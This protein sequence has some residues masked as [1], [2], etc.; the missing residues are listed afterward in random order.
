MLVNRISVVDKWALANE[1]DGVR[2]TVQA[3]E[4]AGFDPVDCL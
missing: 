4:E 3:L 2:N 1:T